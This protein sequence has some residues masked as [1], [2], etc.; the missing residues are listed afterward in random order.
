MPH[1]KASAQELSLRGT[2]TLNPPL[3]KDADQCGQVQGI[4]KVPLA[5]AI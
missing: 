2:G 3:Q 1:W 5:A 4:L